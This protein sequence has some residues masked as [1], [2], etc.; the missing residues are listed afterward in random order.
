MVKSQQSR[1]HNLPEDA[2]EIAR[3]ASLSKLDYDRERDAAAEAL[4]CRVTVLDKLVE[5]A[6][7]K[8]AGNHKGLG[9]PLV[10]DE[11]EPWPTAVDG[12]KLLDAI[13]EVLE[14]FIVMPDGAANAI[15]LWTLHTYVFQAAMI[16]PRLLLKSAQKRSGKTTLLTII[17]AICARPL[18]SANVTAAAVFRCVELAQPTLLIDE[19]D[20]F[21]AQDE[22][23]RG[24]LNA[25]F[26]K[27]GQAVRVVGDQ[28]EPRMFSCWA[29]VAIAAIRRL[30]DTIEDRSV[31]IML[32]RRRRDEEV[33][34]LRSDRLDELVPLAS[35]A[36][37]WADDNFDL[38]V[39]SDPRVPD[40]L[41]DRAADCWRILFAIAERAGGLWPE[42]ARNA[43]LTLSTENGDIETAGTRLLSD[44]RQLF[45]EKATNRLLSA[46]IVAALVAMEHRSWA[47]WGKN[48]E[49]LSKV[50]LA[51]LLG[52]FG[53]RPKDVRLKHLEGDSPERK[54]R[55]AK[56]YEL[57]ERL[58]DV[59]DRYLAPE[60]S[61]IFEP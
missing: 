7:E 34:K 22:E 30:P 35:K 46:D 39:E 12:A 44:L 32:V 36:R 1:A 18:Y 47:E 48:G 31:A 51:R 5:V 40:Q 20:T 60:R 14:R 54:E 59:F 55:I 49:P 56:G 24:G 15:A 2:L 45:K 4:G 38:L 41:N 8:S 43:A 10:F 33:E 53:I 21:I 29:P 58:K 16:T 57:D 13:V 6:R 42:H 61:G 27:G 50:Q 25:G 52:H 9:R 11:P 19:G 37:R 23:L 17:G 28:H 26:Q 3:L